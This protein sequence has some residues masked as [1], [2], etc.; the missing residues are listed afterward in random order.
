MLFPLAQSFR[1]KPK[2]VQKVVHHG[3]L[4]FRLRI[5]CTI[6]TRVV[7]LYTFIH[8]LQIVGNECLLAQCFLH[9]KKRITERNSYLAREASRSSICI[10]CQAKNESRQTACWCG[11]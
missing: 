6:C 10:G 11:D 4:Y 8:R 5:L 3:R 2:A 7:L 9:K 1:P